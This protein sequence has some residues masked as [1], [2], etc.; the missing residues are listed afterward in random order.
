MIFEFGMT[1]YT[2]SIVLIAFLPA[3]NIIW[4]PL[5]IFSMMALIHHFT[6]KRSSKK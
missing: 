5:N 1:G 4:L 2:L 6:E 3:F